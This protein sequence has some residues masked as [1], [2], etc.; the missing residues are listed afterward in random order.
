MANGINSAF[1]GLKFK[2][3]IYTLFTSFLWFTVLVEFVEFR[4][5][6]WMWCEVL[7][8]H[9]QIRQKAIFMRLSVR[10]NKYVII[11]VRGSHIAMLV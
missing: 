1:K 9:A 7:R 3:T 6:A 8:A 2:V 5:F 11:Q 10:N 4:L